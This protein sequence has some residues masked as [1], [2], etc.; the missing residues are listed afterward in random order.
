MSGNF[1]ESEIIVEQ[2]KGAR[3]RKSCLYCQRRRPE[4]LSDIVL[5]FAQ[6]MRASTAKAAAGATTNALGYTIDS[7]QDGG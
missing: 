5:A 1:L 2:P 3:L 7:V 6:S 4:R